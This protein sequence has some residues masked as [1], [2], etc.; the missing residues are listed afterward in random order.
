LGD[1]NREKIR[2]YLSTL[3]EIREFFIGVIMTK[4]TVNENNEHKHTRNSFFL[5]E[6][7]ALLKKYNAEIEAD[8]HYQGY[9]ECGQDIRITIDFPDDEVVFDRWIDPNSCEK[10]NQEEIQKIKEC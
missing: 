3:G 4:N 5:E 7:A 2:K 8:D 1:V 9:P 6:L 10:K